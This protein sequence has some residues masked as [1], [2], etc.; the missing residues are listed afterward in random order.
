MAK[1][2][3]F[4]MIAKGIL[5]GFFLRILFDQVN[6]FMELQNFKKNVVERI[7]QQ[8]LTCDQQCPTCLPKEVF[9]DQKQFVQQ[10]YKPKGMYEVTRWMLFD[11]VSVYDII[12]EEPKI[13]I[14]GHWKDEIKVMT[15]LSMMY[16]NHN[17]LLGQKWSLVKLHNGL[18]KT[19]SMRGTEFLIDVITVPQKGQPKK[20]DYKL[21]R[22]HLVHPLEP[23]DRAQLKIVKVEATPL[24]T[25]VVPT[26]QVK[27]DTLFHSVSCIMCGNKENQ[28][29]R[30]APEKC[31]PQD[32]YINT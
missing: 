1:G 10:A 27:H 4:K 8:C 15:Q 18:M 23:I 21:F 5:Y 25:L 2:I 11:D 22:V 13:T 16:I 9:V 19:D 20:E 3:Q 12:N 6:N 29:A 7:Q 17:R 28:F 31:V 26:S 30:Y 14:T 32:S 24:I